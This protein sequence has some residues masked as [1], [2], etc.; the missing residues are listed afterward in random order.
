MS[1]KRIRQFDRQLRAEVAPKLLQRN[2]TF[3]DRTF[4][5]AVTHEGTISTQIVEF[6]VG[7]KRLS[8]KFTVNLA[9]YNADVSSQSLSPSTTEPHSYD[10][11]FDLVQRLGFFRPPQLTLFDRLLRRTRIATDYWWMQHENA[12]LM[13]RELNDVEEVLLAHGLTWLETH[14][15]LSAFRWARRQRELRK[16]KKLASD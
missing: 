10:C 12:Q 2:F 15:S 13:R 16:L 14:T 3:S 6:Q 9:V 7:Q 8:G 4:R 11:Q 5:R 1:R